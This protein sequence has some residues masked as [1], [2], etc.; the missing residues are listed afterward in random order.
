MCGS[1]S[2]P[3]PTDPKATAETQ[4]KYN[5]SAGNANLQANA[6][7][8]STPF[9]SLQYTPTTDPVTGVT[10]YT[11]TQTLDP[12]NQ[13]LLDTLYGTKAQAGQGASNVLQ[14]AYQGAPDL[15]GTSNSLTNQMMSGEMGY[16]SPFFSQQS[17]NLDNQLRNQGLMPG[18]P[19]YDNAMNTMRQSQGQ[20]VS[21]AIAQFQPQ[22]FQEATTA[23]QMPAQMAAQLSAL[24]GPMGLGLTNTPTTSYGAANYQGAVQAS[25]QMAMDKYKSDQAANSAMV[26]G[27]AQGVGAVAGGAMMRSDRRAKT[28]VALVGNLFDG[29]PVY[30]FRYKSGGPVQIGVM[31]QDIEGTNPEAVAEINGVKYVDY[32]KA[33]AKSAQMA[34]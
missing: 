33:T 17:D 2:A 19:A 27:L 28:D 24:G 1:S 21:G 29:T 3:T 14:G 22:A 12:K 34:A 32:A 16:L 7:N 4:N 8:Q 15:V 13:A 11:A 9:G 30:R 5:L 10:S 23:Y 25:D 6:M 26:S 20:T 31:A 18:T